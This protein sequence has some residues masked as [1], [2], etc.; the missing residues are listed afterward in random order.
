MFF[1][2]YFFNIGISPN[3]EV[4]YMKSLRQFKNMLMQGTVSPIFD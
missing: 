2:F 4:I 3:I 1:H